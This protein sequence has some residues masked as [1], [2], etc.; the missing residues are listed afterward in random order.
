MKTIDLLEE[1]ESKIC[2]EKFYNYAQILNREYNFSLNDHQ[3]W[4]L[5]HSVFGEEY[6]FIFKK[7]NLLIANEIIN[8]IVMKYY[9]G[10]KF[11]K[12][13][14]IKKFIVNKQDIVLFE[15]YADSSRVDLCRI[16][17]KSIAYEIKTEV[18]NLTR[19]SKQ[20]EDYSKLFE[21]IYIILDQRH[22]FKATEI[23][24]NYVGIIVYKV[25]CGKFSFCYKRKASKNKNID[26]EAQIRNLSSQDMSKI[27]KKR[28]LPIP[29][30]K[31]ERAGILKK[32]FDKKQINFLFKDI[33]KLKYAEQWYFIKTNFNEIYPIDIQSFFHNPIDPK[34]AYYK[35]TVISQ[36]LYKYNDSL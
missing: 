7:Y 30:T 13:N 26:S 23:I 11:I 9:P 1:L 10:E 25:Q 21:Y 4:K 31:D 5:I 6:K 27:L 34:L 28:S 14:F 2:P 18:D 12:Y 33:I 24:P 3:L 19:L 20:I 17:G 32:S 22:L 29:S 8:K 15:M 16:N 36:T 35:S